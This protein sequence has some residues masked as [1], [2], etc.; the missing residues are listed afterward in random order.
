[1]NK[2][3][4]P[5]LILLL[6]VL[7]AAQNAPPA[8]F[9]KGSPEEKINAYFAAFN[10]GDEEVMTVYYN[11]NLSPEAIRQRSVAQR[12]EFYRQVRGDAKTVTVRRLM[13]AAD[14]EINALAQSAG[15]DWFSF[16]FMFE[17]PPSTKLSGVRVQRTEGPGAPGPGRTP[18]RV[19][20]LPLTA[21]QFA[22]EAE[23]Y[24]EDHVKNDEFS[25]VV[26]IAKNDQKIFAKAFGLADKEKNTPNKLDTKFNLGS[27][28]KSFTQVAIG[29]LVRQGKIS[30]DDKLGKFLPDYPNREAAEKVTVRQLL[31]M[32]SG[33]GDI[34]GAK[35]FAAP[36]DKLRT[37]QDFIPLFADE[38][39]AFE[40]G[41]KNQYSNGGYVLLGAIIEKVT[42]QSYYDYVRENTYQ[43]LGMS[44]T[45]FYESDKPTPNMAEGYTKDGVRPE[46]KE[47]RRNNL[48][49]RS[50]RGTSAGGGYSTAEDLLK[51]AL[52]LQTGKV[53]IPDESPG[54]KD[55]SGKFT[56]FGIAG[57][58]PG[59]NTAL[60]IRL[61]DGYTIIVLSNYDPPSA[62]K[63]SRQLRE[64]LSR[65]R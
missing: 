57:G 11:E 36:K 30:Y 39:L 64:Y 48:D 16:N 60:S 5:L 49:T 53:P 55:A 63:V 50:A 19:A 1:M 33:I 31:T 61:A 26:L 13:R 45:D 41:T 59:I 37:I 22:A 18:E 15:G 14:N 10:S 12:V 51:Y 62:E 54:L 44:A 52:A 2:C 9:P 24:L 27:L 8:N 40:P 46:A 65:V 7:A 28:N 17:L 6:T 38:P 20:S 23:K 42:G 43:P 25:G 32:T 4:L 56:E 47:P 21:A 58:A 3:L 35:F 34:F 29:Q